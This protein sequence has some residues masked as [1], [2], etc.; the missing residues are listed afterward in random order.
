MLCEPTNMCILKGFPTDLVAV[1]TTYVDRTF[2]FGMW[3]ANDHTLYVADEGTGDNTYDARPTP[4]STRRRRRSRRP[5]SRSGCSTRPR[6]SGISPTRSRT[7]STS[8]SRT[9]CRV[10]RPAINGPGGPDGPWSP[11]TDGLR[12]LT[13][14]VSRDGIATIWAI[15][16]TVSGSGDRVPTRTSSSRSPI[17]RCDG[18]TAPPWER[19]WTLRTAQFGEV[20]RGV[21]FTPGT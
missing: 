20:L 4:T 21:S 16:S 10:T 18:P 1:A 8:V 12:A 13:G 2:P 17:A 5:A 15:T 7:G 19:F 11:A 9:R 3:F 14:R 6:S